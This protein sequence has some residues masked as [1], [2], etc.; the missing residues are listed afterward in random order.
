MALTK[1]NVR[2]LDD[3][4]I[5]P[6]QFNAVGDGVADDTTALNAAMA[7]AANKVLDGGG[8]TYKVSSTINMPSNIVFQNAT[9]TFATDS[10]ICLAATGTQDTALSLAAD[11]SA[12]GRVLTL[13]S[14]DAATL[15]E[16]D[17]VYITDSQDFSTGIARSEINFVKSVSGTSVTMVSDF[18][19]PYTVANSATVSKIHG[20]ENI[21]LRNIVLIGKDDAVTP[22]NQSAATFENCKNVNLETCKFE[23]FDTRLATFARCAHVH[24]SGCYFSNADRFGFGYGT[25]ASKGTHY[26]TVTNCTFELLRH[27]VTT[28][29]SEGINRFLTVTNCTFN[30]MKDAMLDTHAPTDFTNY[31][32]NVGTHVSDNLADD[33][34]VIQGGRTIICNNIIDRPVRHGILIQQGILSAAGASEI[35]HIISNNIINNVGTDAG[36]FINTQDADRENIRGLVISNNTISNSSSVGIRIEASGNS[37]IDTSITGNTIS[38]A[39]GNSCI[40]LISSTASATDGN[41]SRVAITG[42]ALSLSSDTPDH[43]IEFVSGAGGIANVTI[44]GNSIFNGDYGIV[45]GTSNKVVIVGN[46][47]DGTVTGDISSGSATNTTIANNG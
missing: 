2:M 13:S 27:G 12:G 47:I 46:I 38:L 34:I 42:N 10:D 43:N 18:F 5:T 24:V 4:F 9:L 11:V 44:S 33:G 3:V 45:L 15:S 36:I 31:S 19:T 40:S 41:I 23:K 7:A 32:N 39:T 14:G 29:G 6:S 28:G 30:G 16:G 1:A 35:S 26:M 25:T 8:K 20:K 21:T 37:I 17:M 22:A